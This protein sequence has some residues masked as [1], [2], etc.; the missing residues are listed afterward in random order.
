VDISC[1]D[2]GEYGTSSVAPLFET[3]NRICSKI[4]LQCSSAFVSINVCLPSQLGK[5]VTWYSGDSYASCTSG[6]SLLRSAGWNGARIVRI[7]L[8]F[9][10]PAIRPGRVALRHRRLQQLGRV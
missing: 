3:G 6:L 1:Y 2:N 9:S 10:P 7:A 4:Q 5:T 8:S